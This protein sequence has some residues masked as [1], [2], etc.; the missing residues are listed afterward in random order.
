LQLRTWRLIPPLQLFTPNVNDVSYNCAVSKFEEWKIRRIILSNIPQFLHP[1]S[2]NNISKYA[3][4]IH[5]ESKGRY[6]IYY[7]HFKFHPLQT[8]PPISLL[9]CYSLLEVD[10]NLSS[11]YDSKTLALKNV[12]TK[13]WRAYIYII[14]K[15]LIFMPFIPTYFEPN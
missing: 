9:T 14:E 4:I 3:S 11:T 1:T 7:L 15:C 8:D 10:Q 13:I 5:Y 12:A 6:G 2:Y